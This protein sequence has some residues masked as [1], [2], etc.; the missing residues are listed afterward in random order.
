MSSRS[1]RVLVTGS[2]GLLAKG[3]EETIPEGARLLGV[4]LRPYSVRSSHAEHSVLDTRDADAVSRYF[5]DHPVDVVIHAAGMAAVD[6]VEKPPEEGR[7]SNVTGTINI[8]EACR[9]GGAP[10]IYVST[11]AVFDGTSPPYSEE[12]P[13][14]RATPTS[15]ASSNASGSLKAESRIVPSCAPS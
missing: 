1:L 13:R 8:A 2:T 4:H 14:G 5:D 7:R 12:A 10:L 11:N 15:R 6:H 3:L 9:R